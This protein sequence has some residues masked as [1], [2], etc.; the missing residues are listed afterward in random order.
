MFYCFP[1]KLQTNVPSCSFDVTYIYLSVS[2]IREEPRE[3]WV[4][5]DKVF[6][7]TGLEEFPSTWSR[8]VTCVLF[9]NNM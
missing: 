3:T 4:S 6:L 8:K 1:S 7:Q 9:F 5:K 2:K